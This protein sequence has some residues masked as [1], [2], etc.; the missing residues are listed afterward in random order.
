MIPRTAAALLAFSFFGA[1]GAVSFDNVKPGTFPPYWTAAS[2]GPSEPAKWE[3][4][5]D[6]TAPSRRN[7][8]ANMSG[9]ASNSEFPLAI[10]DKV[11]CRDGD[12]SVKF[13][14]AATAR[15]M[16]AAGIVWR[17]Q[18]PQNYYL[19]Q[20]SVD[21]RNIGLFRVQ[22]GQMRAIPVLHGGKG[23]AGVS[24]ELRAGQ[25]YEAKVVFRGNRLRILF[26]NRELFDAVD[27]SLQLPGKTGLWTRGGTVASFDDFRIDRK[28]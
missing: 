15:T 23:E 14:I 26:D 6:S 9:V 19:L 5:L 28:G 8:F 11:V 3:V 18:D 7:V 2:S 4:R 10:F 16:K 24:H 13:K 25:W 21:Q 12:V 22:N 1:G 17:F 20:F 27:D